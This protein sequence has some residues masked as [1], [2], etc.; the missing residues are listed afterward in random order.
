MRAIKGFKIA[1]DV[2]IRCFLKIFII[3]TRRRLDCGILFYLGEKGVG[4][5]G[6]V[7]QRTPGILKVVINDLKGNERGTM[8]NPA[9]DCLRF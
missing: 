3:W 1:R 2:N 8:G 7:C 6:L 4:D 9:K 5:K